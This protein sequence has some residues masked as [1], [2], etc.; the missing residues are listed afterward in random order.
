MAYHIFGLARDEANDPTVKQ[1]DNSYISKESV[2]NGIYAIEISSYGDSP[3]MAFISILASDR[4][5]GIAAYKR[6]VEA[7]RFDFIRAIWGI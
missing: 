3:E 1:E 4:D 7:Y 6:V 2:S 5:L